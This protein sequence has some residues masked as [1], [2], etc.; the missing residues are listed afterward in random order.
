MIDDL[1]DFPRWVDRTEGRLSTLEAASDR[2]AA[3][4]AIQK[5]L[6]AAM[7][8]DLSKIQVE[9]RAQ[10][11][12]LQALADTQSEHTSTLRE[13]GTILREH[14]TILREHSTQLTE[15]RVGVQTIISLL[16]PDSGSDNAEV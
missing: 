1:D 14:G 3:T 2:Q 13:H 12:L 16:T 15:I 6:R 7:D 5:G 10:R 9:F 11:G 4:I 8:D